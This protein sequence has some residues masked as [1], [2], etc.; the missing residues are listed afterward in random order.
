MKKCMITTILISLLLLLSFSP[1]SALF[2]GGPFEID[3]DN[4]SAL[5][6][7]DVPLPPESF[8]AVGL[9]SKAF[10]N[11]PDV[12]PTVGYGGTDYTPQWFSGG[13]GGK[14]LHGV[15]QNVILSE[16]YVQADSSINIYFD[17]Q[18]N[19]PLSSDY[20][21]FE[22]WMTE[23]TDLDF[24]TNTTDYLPLGP[25]DFDT[26]YSN[27]VTEPDTET[28][29]RGRF[30]M[31]Q[32]NDPVGGLIDAV[33]GIKIPA[34]LLGGQWID[35]ITTPFGLSVNTFLEIDPTVGEG[36]FLQQGIYGFGPD[37]SSYDMAIQNVRL[38]S[39]TGGVGE[40]DQWTASDDGIRGAGTIPEP[41]TMILLGFGLLAF[42][43]ISRKKF[44]K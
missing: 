36:D 14:F 7:G 40:M 6:D 21:E 8:P 35:Q 34:G 32:Y 11:L 29:L 42:A 33:A 38:F 3:L 16:L 9:E 2:R 23:I 18:T 13:D 17:H 31:S 30:A 5:Y 26:I 43:G 41:A 20:W 15:E 25:D 27:I 4:W 24:Q 22:L 1:A 44:I 28:I 19:D 39:E 10:L 12:S 37:G